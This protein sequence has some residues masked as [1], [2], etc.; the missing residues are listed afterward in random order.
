MDPEVQLADQKTKLAELHAAFAT[1]LD[2]AAAAHRAE[3][4]ERNF[5][6]NVR[7]KVAADKLQLAIE[8]DGALKERTIALERKELAH[9]EKHE[10]VR[11]RFA[12]LISEMDKDASARASPARVGS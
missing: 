2:V 10:A 12:A 9:N 7:E 11:S 8:L 1:R 3:C 6:L 5:E 4:A